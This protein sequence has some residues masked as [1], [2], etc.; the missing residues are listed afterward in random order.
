MKRLLC[1]LFISLLLSGCATTSKYPGTIGKTDIRKL[2][3]L[4]EHIS[5]ETAQQYANTFNARVFY[6]PSRGAIADSISNSLRGTIGPS[7]AMRHL[8]AELESMNNTSGHWELIVPKIGKRYFLVTL[9]NMEDKAV[10]NS[11]GE[12][13]LPESPPNNQ[14]DNEVK[15][16]FGN[17]WHTKYQ[18]P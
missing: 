6:S 7:S 16:V 15:R 5:Q 1:F 13:Y 17:S 14:I 12:V 2:V 10:V 3:I 8:I 9:R 4:G 11:A 18:N